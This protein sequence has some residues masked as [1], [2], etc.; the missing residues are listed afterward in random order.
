MRR[1]DV[2]NWNKDTLKPKGIGTPEQ[3][4]QVGALADGV[5]VGSAFV[6]TIGG[7]RSPV[8]T[9]KESAKS[10]REALKE[11]QP[12]HLLYNYVIERRFTVHIVKLIERR[13][14]KHKTSI[15][16]VM[17][18]LSISLLL[19]GLGLILIK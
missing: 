12:I 15:T 16:A 14:P 18:F 13:F 9:A 17:V 4:K 3:A 19:L 5:I 6:K 2:G 11:L 7:S 8:D 10:F 1:S